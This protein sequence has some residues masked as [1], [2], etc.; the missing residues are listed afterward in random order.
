[1]NHPNL[2]TNH[3]NLDGYKMTMGMNRLDSDFD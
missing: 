1:M 2:G 3:L